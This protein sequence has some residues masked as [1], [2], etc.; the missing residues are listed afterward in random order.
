MTTLLI[1]WHSAWILLTCSLIRIWHPLHPRT[2]WFDTPAMPERKETFAVICKPWFGPLRSIAASQGS[3]TLFQN[4]HKGYT[5]GPRLT[6]FSRSCPVGTMVFSR[7]HFTTL[8]EAAQ[9]LPLCQ[10]ITTS[11]CQHML[12][13]CV[14]VERCCYGC[15]YTVACTLISYY[16]CYYTMEESA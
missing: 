13:C 4:F 7:C 14:I 10:N 6:L 15:L 1:F 11:P 3:T 16:S 5:A 9:P 8:Y 12:C 2:P